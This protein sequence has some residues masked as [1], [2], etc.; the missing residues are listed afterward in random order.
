MIIIAQPKSDTKH[1]YSR[2]RS[3]T[4]SSVS[5]C[6]GRDCSFVF[7]CERGGREI[8]ISKLRVL[9]SWPCLFL[10]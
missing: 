10:E 3:R 8:G 7:K 5:G 9:R 4:R 1:T 6:P 2:S